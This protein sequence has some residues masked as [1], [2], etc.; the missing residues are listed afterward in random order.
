MEQI[1]IWPSAEDVIQEVNQQA[2]MDGDPE[3]LEMR[4]HHLSQTLSLISSITRDYHGSII[5]AADV[6]A[7]MEVLDEY[8]LNTRLAVCRMEHRL[9]PE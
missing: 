9:T 7:L 2:G 4:L 1:I 3:G 6:S 5:E 8:V